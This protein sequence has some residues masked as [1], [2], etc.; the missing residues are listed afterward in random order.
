MRIDFG[1]GFGGFGFNF[2]GD[3]MELHIEVKLGNE[4]IKS[5]FRERSLW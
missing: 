5:V 2:G 3:M 4:I 1:Q